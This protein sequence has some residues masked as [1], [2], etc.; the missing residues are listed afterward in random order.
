MIKVPK[1]YV[2]L[3]LN[4]KLLEISINK[5]LVKSEINNLWQMIIIMYF[6]RKKFKANGLALLKNNVNEVARG[7]TILGKNLYYSYLYLKELLILFFN[8]FLINFY[9]F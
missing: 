3:L 7:L 1:N 2:D 8:D 4:V 9:I 5:D 6:I